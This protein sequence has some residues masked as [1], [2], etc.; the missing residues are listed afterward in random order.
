MVDTP[1]GRTSTLGNKEGWE[2]KKNSGGVVLWVRRE[3]EIELTP[4]SEGG[5]EGGG[6]GRR[7]EVY[8]EVSVSPR[9]GEG[10]S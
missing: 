7:G 1:Q 2:K 8:G 10:G 3:E 9:V 4:S 5:R 6:G